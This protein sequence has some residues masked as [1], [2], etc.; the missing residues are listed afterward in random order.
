MSESEKEGGL[1]C[2]NAHEYV[3]QIQIIVFFLLLFSFLETF[4]DVWTSIRSQM[5]DL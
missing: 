5:H 1:G 4:V 3:C 2:G